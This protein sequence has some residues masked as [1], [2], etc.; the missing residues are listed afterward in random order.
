MGWHLFTVFSGTYLGDEAE[1][2]KSLQD[3]LAISRAKIQ[4]ASLP[5]AALGIILTASRWSDVYSLKSL[6]FI[7]LFFTLLTY[8]CNLNCLYDLD[9][10]SKFKTYMSDAVRSFGIPRLIHLLR[11]ELI[12]TV[13]LI[14]ALCFLEKTPLYT[15][16][17]FGML[18]G[19]V[20]SA[21]P[22]RM[23][24]RGLLSFTPVMFGLYFLPIPAGGFLISQRIS[25][26]LILFA[27]G[28]ALLMQ[29]ITFIN[30]CEDYEEDKESGIQT[31]V[32]RVGIRE[33]LHLG[34]VWV[35]GGGLLCIGM[36]VAIK[37]ARLS[38]PRTLVFIVLAAL[39]GTVCLWI[40]RTFYF[41][42][43]AQDPLTLC[44][45]YSPRMRYWFMLTRYPLMAMALLL[46]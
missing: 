20:Y 33:T 5:T 31:F 41:T 24:S 30:T 38:G 8:A 34:T 7:V 19:F 22:L 32:H 15:L 23:K 9:V 36:L 35:V 21:P 26:E 39:F 6:L 43:R 13:I 14:T 12:L 3:F 45:S 40:V 27:L 18:C 28:Y 17:L 44:K 4:L 29:G 46:V 1:M 42:S 25:L 2:K 16:G 11:W 37:H 10:D